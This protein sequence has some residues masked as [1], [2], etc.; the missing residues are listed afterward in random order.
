MLRQFV[1]RARPPSFSP[2][3]SP[4]RLLAMRW[5]SY[6]VLA[7]GLGLVAA[8]P[9]AAAD[10]PDNDGDDYVTCDGCTSTTGRLGGYCGLCPI[11]ACSLERKVANCAYCAE[12]DACDKLAGFFKGAPAAQATLDEIRRML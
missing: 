7:I 5:L 3:T 8:A 4:W 9:A 12:Y 6:A 11:R 10:C 2:D 1:L